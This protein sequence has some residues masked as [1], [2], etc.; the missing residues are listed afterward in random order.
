MLL[1]AIMIGGPA[2]AQAGSCPSP[3]GT[4]CLPDPSTIDLL[5]Q[6]I[7]AVSGLRADSES[8]RIL[9]QNARSG[10]DRAEEFRKYEA[11][12]K[13]KADFDAKS[14]SLVDNI[15]KAYNVA[16]P[17]TAGGTKKPHG[18]RGTMDWVD[19]INAQWTPRIS[20]NN[21]DFRAI[22]T[23]GGT[24]YASVNT[25]AFAGATLPNGDV[26]IA[27]SQL[28]DAIQFRNPGILAQTIYHESVHFNELI[29]TGWKTTQDTEVSAYSA[30]EAHDDVFKLPKDILDKNAA[31]LAAN[32]AALLAGKGSAYV[33]TPKEEKAIKEIVDR[34]QADEVDLAKYYENLKTQVAKD[35]AG[36]ESDERL[37][38]SML[39]LA[40]RSCAVPGSVAQA[41]IDAL[42]NPYQPDFIDRGPYPVTRG[43]CVAEVYAYLG[44]GGATAT[45]LTSRSSRL[46]EP[47]AIRPI[48]TPPA[49]RPVPPPFSS[50]LPII[51]EFARAAC[52]S[53]EQAPLSSALYSSY[54][55]SHWAY[56]D[57]IAKDLM[58]DM[59]ACQRQLFQQLI[60]AIRGNQAYGIDRAWIR[61]MVA[62]NTPAPESGTT[63]GSSPGGG[64]HN[65]PDPRLPR[66]RI[67]D[68]FGN[69]I[70]R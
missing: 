19:G 12:L 23:R 49:A 5:L 25:A 14:A 10:D 50:Y 65:G 1:M 70:P 30:V 38:E 61:R 4:P 18:A 2:L 21:D 11:Y 44:E 68:R 59:G 29:T 6:Q 32:R 63:P 41:E 53:P 3:T 36:R 56:D 45:E 51:K 20:A 66:D 47:I 69:I 48:T 31:E 27:S 55:F 33:I 42:P 28:A 62:M 39:D 26:I 67:R 13:S 54:N 57:M 58:V 43:Q 35:K 52:L 16:P 15:Q 34:Q 7:K 37:R 60:D 64:E 9:W 22:K 17:R 40:V 46:Q 24:H 8:N